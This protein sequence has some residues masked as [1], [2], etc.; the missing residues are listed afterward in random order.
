MFPFVETIR[1]EYGEILRLPYHQA[2]IDHTFKTFYKQRN[3]ILLSSVLLLP[4]KHKRDIV[5]L[6]FLYSDVAYKL[7][8]SLL[9]T[10]KVETLKIVEANDIDYSLKFIDRTQ[11]NELF[12][13]RGDCDDVLIVKNGFITDTSIAN[14]FFFDGHEMVTPD[15]PLLAGTHR[16]WL[17]DNGLLKPTTIRI[18]DLSKFSEFGTINAL[19]GNKLVLK[20]I[21]GIIR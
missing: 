14:V 4:E 18:D 2:R 10:R 9:R 11:I 3:S 13:D 7:E 8:F 20:P 21:A 12:R 15:T 5:K 6:R 19:S 1:I 17:V 16:A